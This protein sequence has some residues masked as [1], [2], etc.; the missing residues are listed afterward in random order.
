MHVLRVAPVISF[1]MTVDF[2][3]SWLKTTAVLLD[4]LSLWVRNLNRFQLYRVA[5][6][7]SLGGSQLKAALKV[8]EQPH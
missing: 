6:M 2:K 8:P 1:C 4:P 5:L 7:G 3:T